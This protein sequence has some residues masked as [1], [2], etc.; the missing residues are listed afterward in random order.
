M[1]TVVVLQPAARQD[2]IDALNWYEARRPGLG[3][4]F[5][6]AVTRT[7]NLISSSPEMFPIVYRDVRRALVRPFP[8]GVFYRTHPESIHVLALLHGRRDPGTWQ[9]RAQSD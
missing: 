3:D 8:F 6:K 4:R 5:M 1:N 9:S 2:L 7:M